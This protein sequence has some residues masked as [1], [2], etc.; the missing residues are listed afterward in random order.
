MIDSTILHPLCY[1]NSY[2][3]ELQHEPLSLFFIDGAQ[4]AAGHEHGEVIAQR[5]SSSSPIIII[6]NHHHHQSSSSSSPIIVIIVIITP[7]TDHHDHH[8][9]N[10][11]LHLSSFHNRY[12]TY[13]VG[14]FLT[15]QCELSIFRAL[16]KFSINKMKELC[17]L[18][19]QFHIHY[20]D[21]HIFTENAK[22]GV[23]IYKFPTAQPPFFRTAPLITYSVFF[24]AVLLIICFV[25]CQYMYYTLMPW[26]ITLSSATVVNL[27]LLTSDLYTLLFGLLLFGY[28][29]CV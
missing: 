2:W 12:C 4:F 10:L 5:K 26:V 18:F 8:H 28:K 27:S 3:A 19:E 6:T 24:I 25:V 21:R 13:V 11:H 9:R 22:K 17:M 1:T 16:Y 23:F 29:V 20:R 7:S 15:L 14:K